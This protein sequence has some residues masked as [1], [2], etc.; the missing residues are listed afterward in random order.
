MEVPFPQ[1]YWVVPGRLLA[2]C[3]PQAGNERTSRQ[4]LE[5]LLDA[6]IRQFVSL[7]EPVELDWDDRPFPPYENRLKDLAD[8][9]GVAV[10]FSRMPIRDMSV[11]TDGHMEKILDLIDRSIGDQRPVYV[12]CLGGRG[13]TGTVVGCYLARHGHAKSLRA[14]DLINTLRK[15]TVDHARPSPETPEQV[16]MVLRWP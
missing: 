11:P 10:A 2:G 16:N 9:R 12:H 5:N 14:L 7:M 15:D 3:Y 13:R 6:G 1:S 4:M 8:A